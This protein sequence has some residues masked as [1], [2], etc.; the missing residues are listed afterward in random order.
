MNI[1]NEL[2]LRGIAAQCTNEEKL[3]VAFENCRLKF[4]IGFDPTADSLHV[5]HLSQFILMSRLQKLGHTPICLFGGG[6][7]AIGDPSGKSDLRRV[8]TFEEIDYNISCFKKQSEK[9]LDVSNVIFLNNANW[10]RDLKYVDFLREIGSHFSVNRM[11]SAEC[12][13][14]RL[15]EGLT[16][17]ELNYMLMQAYDF[18]VINK[19][20]G[21]VLQIG[22]NDQ[23]SNIIAG[24]ELVRKKTSNEVFG[25]TTNLLTTSDGKKMGKTEKGAVW[26][27]AKK[28]SPYDF[29]QYWRGVSDLD[30]CKFLKIFTFLS[31]DEI[32]EYEKL[33]GEKLNSAKEILAFELTLLVH[34]KDEAEESQR[35]S[36]SIFGGY[37]DVSGMP[38]KV[39]AN[40]IFKEEMGIFEFLV[41]AGIASSKSEARR[42]SEQGGISL[43][44]KRADINTK[45][46]KEEAEKG[47]LIQK[48][49]KTFLKFKKI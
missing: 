35:I 44:G 37:L 10:I 48:G 17:L 5:G 21:C 22:G 26:L 13:K 3:K 29:Y 11:L 28:T 33:S 24:V 8:M 42:L 12:Y 31:I 49:K 27:D 40:D 4:Y 9:F 6:T 15:A 41:I 25:M 43:D 32:S 20:F 7:G 1:Y 36:R 2:I 18:L 14:I 23:W 34:G 19:N 38:E 39:I 16:F 30:V 46:S 47:I 45:I